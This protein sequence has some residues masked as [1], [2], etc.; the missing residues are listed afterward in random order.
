M[1]K[2]LTSAI[3]VVL[4]MVLNAAITKS[5]D[6]IFLKGSKYPILAKVLEIGLTEIKFKTWP[7]NENTP[8]KFEKKD[9]VWKVILENET[10]LIFSEEKI[11]YES[12]Q[13]TQKKIAF[14]LDP[15]IAIRKVL[16]LSLE[17]DINEKNSVE[18]GAAYIGLGSYAQSAFLIF[19]QAKGGF[20]RLGWKYKFNISKNFLGLH[21]NYIRADII[22]LN[23]INTGNSF[24]EYY[25]ANTEFVDFRF[26]GGGLIFNFGKQ[27]QFKNHWC[28]DA[29]AGIGLG[30]KDKK[31]LH[32]AVVTNIDNYMYIE[33][34]GTFGYLTTSMYFGKI[35]P[36]LQSGLKIGYFIDLSTKD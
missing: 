4:F 11:N 25:I 5:Q 8:E 22:Y 3:L 20:V 31:I 9:K 21:Q 7:V 26:Y 14:K 27:W 12:S 30:G 34:S 17:Y 2:N 24:K 10:V 36:V 29:F 28:L 6:Q 35:A 32:G 33:D 16:S 15:I 23:H 1:I 13:F 19:D 18:L